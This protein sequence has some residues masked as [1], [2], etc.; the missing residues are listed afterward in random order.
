MI[1][2]ELPLSK[3]ET[4]FKGPV[5]SGAAIDRWVRE[6]RDP[7]VERAERQLGASATV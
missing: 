6:Q 3:G 5:T 7:E 2:S 1:G 4:I